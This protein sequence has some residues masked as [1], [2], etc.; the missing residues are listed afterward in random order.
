LDQALRR[1]TIIFGDQIEDM[2]FFKS[3]AKNVSLDIL[4]IYLV[5]FFL[6]PFPTD[7]QFENSKKVKK[8]IILAKNSL[9][10]AMAVAE[11]KFRNYQFFK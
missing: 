8:K 2:I 6:M 5:L 1:T 9:A 11:S 7:I 4:R 3:W 10:T